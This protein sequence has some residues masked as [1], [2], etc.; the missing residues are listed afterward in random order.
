MLHVELVDYFCTLNHDNVLSLFFAL[1]LDMGSFLLA[2]EIQPDL[3]YQERSGFILAELLTVLLLD[4]KSNIVFVLFD[5]LR[6][7]R[8]LVGFP[9]GGF[10]VFL[11]E[12]DELSG[13]LCHVE[14]VFLILIAGHEDELVVVSQTIGPKRI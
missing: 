7:L 13:K 10:V 11:V 5:S 3:L 6:H 4:Y 1:R 9:H 8:I 2:L 14:L 12:I